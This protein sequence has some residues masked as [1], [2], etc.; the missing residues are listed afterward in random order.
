MDYVIYFKDLF[1]SIP[2][3]RKRVILVFLKKN[4]D[5][6]RE[7]AFLKSDNNHLSLEF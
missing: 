5:L 6:I 1:E 2:N 3:Y 7:S 4:D